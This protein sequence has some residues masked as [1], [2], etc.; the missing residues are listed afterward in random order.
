MATVAPVAKAI[1]G[2]L[3]VPIYQGGGEYAGARRAKERP[4]QARIY[5]DL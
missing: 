4:G 2:Q 5:A 3:N 1:V